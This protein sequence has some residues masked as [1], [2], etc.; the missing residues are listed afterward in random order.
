MDGTCLDLSLSL[1]PTWVPLVFQGEVYL[2]P[3]AVTE[4]GQGG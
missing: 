2:P 4:E 1:L 3:L